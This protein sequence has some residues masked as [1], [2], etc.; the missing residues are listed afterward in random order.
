MGSRVDIPTTIGP[1]KVEV[2]LDLRG[3]DLRKTIDRLKAAAEELRM[4][5]V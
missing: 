4:R 2:T 5:Y 3:D 1:D